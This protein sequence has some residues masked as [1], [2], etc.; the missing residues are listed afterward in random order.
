MLFFFPALIGLLL[1]MEPHFRKG[2]KK[3]DQFWFQIWR[4][5]RAK[6]G[7]ISVL[8]HEPGFIFREQSFV[9]SAQCNLL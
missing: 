9:Q 3:W 2:A 4:R 6:F 5:F 7:P 8:D 1:E